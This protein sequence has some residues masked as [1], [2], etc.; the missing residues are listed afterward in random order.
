MGLIRVPLVHPIIFRHLDR[1][2]YRPDT[3]EGDV[4]QRGSLR[5]LDHFL[6]H[7]LLP[8][9]HLYCLYLTGISIT[10]FDDARCTYFCPIFYLR[11]ARR[12]CQHCPAD[13]RCLYCG[14][15]RPEKPV[16]QVLSEVCFFWRRTDIV[17]P[18]GNDAKVRSV[19][20]AKQGLFGT[21]F[22][23]RPHRFRVLRNIAR[24]DEVER[25]VGVVIDGSPFP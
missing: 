17:W 23:T 10:E 12:H 6:D 24:T 1:N 14:S 25:Q 13:F 2:S 18:V 4:G 9:P 22:F 3:L 7:Q 19:C 8:A 5:F 15:N 16:H 21:Y 11:S 20:K